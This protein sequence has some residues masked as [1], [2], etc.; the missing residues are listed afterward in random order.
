MSW[1]GSLPTVAEVKS[2]MIRAILVMVV[3][4]IRLVQVL[5]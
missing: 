3:A 5:R 2:Y 1:L 4:F